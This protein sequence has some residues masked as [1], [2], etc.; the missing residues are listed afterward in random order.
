[1]IRLLLAALQ[2]GH[3]LLWGAKELQVK[4]QSPVQYEWADLALASI[5]RER[6]VGPVDLQYTA[7][8]KRRLRVHYRTAMLNAGL[9]GLAFLAEGRPRRLLADWK[10]ERGEA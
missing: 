7:S 2:A 10:R 1:V 4:V 3:A 9:L 6:K 8:G 5:I